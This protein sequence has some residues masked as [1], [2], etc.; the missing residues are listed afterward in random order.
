[1]TWSIQNT[2]CDQARNDF[3][4]LKGIDVQVPVLILKI[5]ALFVTRHVVLLY[6]LTCM[7]LHGH[8]GECVCVCERSELSTTAAEII[9]KPAIDCFLLLLL[10]LR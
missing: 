2:K 6:M 4:Y 5:G 8:V 10:L 3:K 1:M 7:S 9:L